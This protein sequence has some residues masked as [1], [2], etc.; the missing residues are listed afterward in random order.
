MMESIAGDVLLV[1]L[2]S[3]SVIRFYAWNITNMSMKKV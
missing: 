2:E 1:D 3:T